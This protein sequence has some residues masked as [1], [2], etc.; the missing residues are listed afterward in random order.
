VVFDADGTLWRGDVGEDFL[1]YLAFEGHVPRGSWASYE[2]LL[3]GDHAAAYAFAVEVMAGLHEEA[4]TTL[5]QAFFT[6]RYEG[7]IFPGMR[8]FVEAVRA[9]GLRPWVCSASPFWSVV[10]G[11]AALGI[12]QGQVVAVECE[13]V[14]GRLSRRVHLPVTCGKGKVQ[15][16][17]QRLVGRPVLAVG[18]G[19]LD[20]DML[21]WAE[22]ALVVG[23]P[24]GP[25][26][27]L[28]LEARA[29]GWPVWRL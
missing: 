20:L 4:L 25:D 5:A 27:A 2:R 10:P 24:D 16:L 11:A 1:R 13:R 7:R 26:N 29:R 23:T 22:R 18:N 12:A 21:A 28:V 8:R 17:T 15:A 9:R 19:A 3:E 6:R 14:E